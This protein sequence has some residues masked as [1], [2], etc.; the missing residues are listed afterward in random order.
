MITLENENMVNSVTQLMSVCLLLN[1]LLN[2][3]IVAQNKKWTQASGTVFDTAGHIIKG[4]KVVLVNRKGV[5]RLIT[6]SD[7]N[8]YFGF[9]IRKRKTDKWFIRC[10][11]FVESKPI[12]LCEFMT[13]PELVVNVDVSQPRSHTY[14]VICFA[15]KSETLLL[16]NQLQML[17]QQSVKGLLPSSELKADD[18]LWI[19]LVK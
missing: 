14:T 6:F 2:T 12:A 4:E 3:G 1:F 17:R 18:R 19:P 10:D 7:Q 16:Q 15:Q 8:G 9:N 5:V 13:K 11:G